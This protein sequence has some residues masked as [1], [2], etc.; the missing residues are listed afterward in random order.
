MLRETSSRDSGVLEQRI[1]K[2]EVRLHIW[3]YCQ[4]LYLVQSGV[5]DI[6]LMEGRAIDP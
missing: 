2:Q 4:F 5:T 6:K 1:G 3:D